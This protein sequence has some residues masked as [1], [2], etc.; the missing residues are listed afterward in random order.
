MRRD[1]IEKESIVTIRDLV[2][3]D[4]AVE[5]I[6]RMVAVLIIKIVELVVVRV[7]HRCVGPLDLLRLARRIR[8]LLLIRQERNIDMHIAM[9][10]ITVR[11]TI[12]CQNK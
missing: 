6:H 11:V 2:R 3:P 10:I 8:L 4:H 7:A 5:A 1:L 9:I 12:L